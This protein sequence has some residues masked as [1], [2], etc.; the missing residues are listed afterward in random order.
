M[1]VCVQAD[2]WPSRMREFEP[3]LK[4]I[5]KAQRTVVSTT[6]TTAAE[7]DEEAAALASEAPPPPPVMNT[8]QEAGP[9]MPGGN[10]IPRHRQVPAKNAAAAEAEDA[11]GT[12]A[13]QLKK[14]KQEG[15]G[16]PTHAPGT[17]N[18]DAEEDEMRPPRLFPKPLTKVAP[19]PAK[20]ARVPFF[21]VVD[22]P[23]APAPAPPAPPPAAPPTDG[24]ALLA[25]MIKICPPAGDGQEA[26]AL[27]VARAFAQ[28]SAPAA[29]ERFVDQ[30][31]ANAETNAA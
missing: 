28:N 25:V 16:A 24:A 5:N 27:T 31:R 9:S 20:V 10:W 8:K 7:G 15:S 22:N 14:R 11:D 12:P 30:L 17:V 19:P 26:Y 4:E 3:Q 1:L 18:R 13:A 2:Y 23:A 29:F 21:F 6:T